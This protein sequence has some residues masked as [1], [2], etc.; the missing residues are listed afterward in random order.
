MEK[1]LKAF[2]SK[3]VRITMT[4]FYQNGYTY[5]TEGNVCIRVPGKHTENLTGVDAVT[6]IPWGRIGSRRMFRL[7]LKDIRPPEKD[8]IC[9]ACEPGGK[10]GVCTRCKGDGE[11]EFE[12]DD[13]PKCDG[14][15]FVGPW[16][17]PNCP[18]CLG[19]RW[20]TGIFNIPPAYF[21]VKY[22]QFILSHVGPIEIFQPETDY[23]PMFFTFHGG[24]GALMGLCVNQIDVH[25]AINV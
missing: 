2:C 4:P 7:K 14:E 16:D 20:G 6:T 9:A 22:L 24:E 1:L 19:T 21:A 25:K 5:A 18:E 10:R 3:D 17:T 15:G 8:E 12:G 11:I 23:G 13:C